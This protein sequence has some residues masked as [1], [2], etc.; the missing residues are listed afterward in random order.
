MADRTD[1]T[2]K[3]RELANCNC[4]YGCPCQFN[5]LPSNGSC[6]AVVGFTIEEGRHGSV[7]LDGLNAVAIYQWPQ[8]V[9]LGN[10][11][12][13]LIIDQRADAQQRA[14]LEKILT[15]EDTDDMATMWWVFSKMSP[16]KLATEFAP[17]DIDCDVDKR[18]GRI[19]VA[20]L[21]DTS[22]EPIRNPVTGA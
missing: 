19:T 14:A 13:K 9:H 20:G 10:G 8:A 16:N 15:G 21:V 17:I 1:W 12:M 22:A 4:N 11:T 5:A 6:H 7:R 18:M 2:I 3:G